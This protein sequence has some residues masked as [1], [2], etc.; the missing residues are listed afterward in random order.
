VYHRFF[1]FVGPGAAQLSDLGNKQNVYDGI[2]LCDKE[3]DGGIL[4]HL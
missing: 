2:L 1:I 4:N 3:A